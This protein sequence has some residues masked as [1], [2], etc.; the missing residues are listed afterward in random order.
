MQTAT[1]FHVKPGASPERLDFYARLDKKNT[2]PLWEVLGRLITPFP[3][4]QSQPYLWKYDEL[5][6]LIMEGGRL[7]TAKEAERRVLVLENPGL[8]GMSQITQS[9][10]AGLQLIT[11]GE[12]APTHRHAASALR[13]IVE[14]SGAYTA[15]DGERTTMHPGDFIL[16]PSWTFHDHGNPG[17]EPVV[18]LDGLDVPIVNLFDTS[19]AEHMDHQQPLRVDEGDALAR[20]GN[21]MLPLEYQPTS[22]SAPV[23][24]YPYA[25]SREA[26]ERLHRNGPLH[27]CH[28]T[29][30]QYSNPATGGYPMPTIAAFLQ[31]LPAGFRGEAYRS[32][33]ATVYSVVEGRGET[34]IGDQ[35]FTWTPR[36]ILV[37]P[38]WA[39][40][41][42]TAS[43][44]AVLFSF[45]DRAAQKALGLWREEAPI[46][47]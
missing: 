18:W 31:Y 10:Y 20:Y 43:E 46:T 35:A 25:R 4:P 47:R 11:P 1:T 36:D 14:G 34:R 9:L 22:Q 41:S 38:S 6:P 26:L 12:V 17:S 8:R 42:H 28:G 24:V 45:S 23:F 29:K 3:Q 27:P 33:D 2:A 32:S 21:N 16:T 5:R 13:F 37:V 40:V 19:F 30:V 7:I 39:P 44:D 15:V